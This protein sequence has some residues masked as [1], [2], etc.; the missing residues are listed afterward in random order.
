VHDGGACGRGSDAEW[1]G[2]Q[3]HGVEKHAKGEQ[4]G[5]YLRE[6]K[7]GEMYRKTGLLGK[8]GSVLA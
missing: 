5:R 4:V 3:P 1:V 2:R 6:R 7:M 8:Y